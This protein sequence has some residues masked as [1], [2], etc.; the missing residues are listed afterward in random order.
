MFFCVALSISLTTAWPHRG[1]ENDTLQPF[2]RTEKTQHYESSEAE[3][4]LKKQKKKS[5]T[6]KWIISY[7]ATSQWALNNL[8]Q[9][10]LQINMIPQ[11][12]AAKGLQ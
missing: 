1:L 2:L 5:Q 12:E 4:Q 10:H 3:T 6:A 8:R 11:R 7:L 9:C